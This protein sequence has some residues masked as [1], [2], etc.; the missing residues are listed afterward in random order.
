MTRL[1]I[2][3]RQTRIHFPNGELIGD[4][5]TFATKNF[6]T[7]EK[8]EHAPEIEVGGKHGGGDM[9]LI[10]AFVMAV[11]EN[12]TSFL[13]EGNCTDHALLSHL[14]V[15]AAEK[16]RR[17]GKVIDVKKFEDDVRKQMGI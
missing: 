1:A 10:R 16:S 6:Q 2:C 5:V 11:R 7:G 17:E 4:M 3:D 13:G 8:I 14:V 12:N 9:A 15:F